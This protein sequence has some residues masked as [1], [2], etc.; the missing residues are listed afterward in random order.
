MNKLKTEVLSGNTHQLQCGVLQI[1]DPRCSLQWWQGNSCSSTFSP[2]AAVDSCRD[3]W[4][5]YSP[6][7]CSPLRALR[8]VRFCPPLPR[9]SP[10]HDTMAIGLCCAA[11]MAGTAAQPVPG[12]LC[13]EYTVPAFC[14][15][16][17][18]QFMSST[19]SVLK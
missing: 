16:E 7:S 18:Q 13:P 4:S 8:A 2:G 3:T 6:S 12:H 11:G 1:P 17:Y 14:T 5:N 19:G 10:R 15:E 9:L